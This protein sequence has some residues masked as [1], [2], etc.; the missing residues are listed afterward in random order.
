MSLN[1]KWLNKI[2]T[3]CEKK[4]CKEIY[5]TALTW[6]I[7]MGMTIWP[8]K[9]MKYELGERVKRGC[10]LETINA[11]NIATQVQT[12]IRVTITTPGNS[13]EW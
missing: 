13:A 5:K 8:M 1:T 2:V 12:C 6:D 10:D 4:K 11:L 7:E 9:L 3:Y